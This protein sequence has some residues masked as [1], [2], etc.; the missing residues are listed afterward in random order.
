ME[1]ANFP[2]EIDFLQRVWRYAS[3]FNTQLYNP[4][5]VIV[6]LLVVGVVVYTVLRFLRGTR[7]ARLVQAVLMILAISFLVVQTVAREFKLDRINVLY[8]Y[9]LA[10]VFLVSLVAFQAE[11]RRLLIRIGET[12]F[13]RSWAADSETVIEP[14]VRAASRLGVNKIGALIAVERST[15]LGAVAET[16]VSI[17][18][19][20]SCELLETIFWPGSA[21]HDL[22][23]IIRRGRIVAAGCQFPLSESA[24]ADRAL[25]SRH[26][27]ALGISEEAD[28]VVVV[29]SEETGAIS[30][31]EQGR[32]R[33]N[34]SSDGLREIMVEALIHPRSE[35][36]SK[37]KAGETSDQSAEQVTT[38]GTSQAA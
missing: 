26:R 38:D 13:F 4:W 20:L 25:G 29:V 27:A 30:V 17:D 9:F 18:A 15:E 1:L 37:R 6:E 23:V 8:P 36:E 10:G 32:L 16:G 12:R 35:Q 7:G 22:G 33:R 5:V 24:A 3:R 31:A 2:A 34:V 11:L 14:I 19:E 28:A 21:L